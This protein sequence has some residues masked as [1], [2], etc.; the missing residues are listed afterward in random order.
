MDKAAI[1]LR[2]FFAGQRIKAPEIAEATGYSIS[3][4]RNV[5]CGSD[6]P[7][8]KFQ[9]KMLAVFPGLRDFLPD[10]NGHPAPDG[11]P[12]PGGGAAAPGS[13]KEK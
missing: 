6:D 2:Q 8:P 10:S 12:G 9:A 13:N 11:Q 4:V 3:Y 1:G 7:S 5:L